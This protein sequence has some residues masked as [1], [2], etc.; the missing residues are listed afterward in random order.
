[1]IVYRIILLRCSM[2][3]HACDVN[4][5]HSSGCCS[6]PLRRGQDMNWMQKWPRWLIYLVNEHSALTFADV[7]SIFR[8]APKFSDGMFVVQVHG[9]G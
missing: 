2:R 3:A 8:F 5:K 9:I 6:P 7:P 4:Q 1:M